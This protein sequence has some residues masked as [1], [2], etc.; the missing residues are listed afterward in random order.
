MTTLIP[1]TTHS[2]CRKWHRASHL[3]SHLL[4]TRR[5]SILILILNITIGVTI[6]VLVLKCL[7]RR[8]GRLHEV[9]K[10]NLS[11]FN[12]VNT[13]VHLTQLITKSVKAS[14]HVLKLRHNRLEGY[15]TCKR[16]RCEGRRSERGWR[17]RRLSSWPLRSKL[18]F[19]PSNGH[20]ADGTHDKEVSRLRIGDKHM[21]ND[22]RDSRR[23]N[24]HITGHLIL[25]DINKEKY[26]MRGK[27]NG[28]PFKE[29]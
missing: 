10:A 18:I 19:A 2:F 28:I 7:W 11:S 3:S 29:G 9:T 25:I 16:R 8:K 1:K 20:A 12:T 6:I 26:E 27:F 23:E 13:S 15:T 14:I 17:S 4:V 22:P 21:A 24:K 5:A